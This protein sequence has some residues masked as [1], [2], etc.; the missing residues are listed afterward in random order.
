[1]PHN[2]FPSGGLQRTVFSRLLDRSI[3]VLPANT[4]FHKRVRLTGAPRFDPTSTTSSFDSP[5]LNVHQTQHVDAPTHS[6]VRHRHSALL[7]NKFAFLPTSV[8]TFTSSSTAKRGARMSRRGRKRRRTGG[9]KKVMKRVRKLEKR[10]EVKKD[11]RALNSFGLVLNTGQVQ[12][13]CDIAQGDD[14]DERDGN[15]ITPFRLT[16]RFNWLGQAASTAE[17]YRLIVFQDRQQVVA[18]TPTVAQVLQSS[19]ALSLYNEDFL[20][21]WKILYD[22]MWTGANDANIRLSFIGLITIRGLLPII[23]ATG[24]G[25]DV[26]KNGLYVLAITNVASNAP[27]LVYSSRLFYY[28]S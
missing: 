9:L 3:R 28:D 14:R 2:L 15:K 21:R 17:V 1:M 7:L 22:N 10:A 27:T 26:T 4:R 6:R 12:N 8:S 19:G 16:I 18:T 11:D 13:W 25:T 5:G 24:T 20:K 23:Y